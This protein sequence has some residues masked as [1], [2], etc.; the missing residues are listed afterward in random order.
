ML[1]PRNGECISGLGEDEVSGFPTSPPF[2]SHLPDLSQHNS[3]ATEVLRESPEIYANLKNAETQFG[4]T[5]GH[6]IKSG[7]DLKGHPMI[8]KIGLHAGDE[9]SYEVFSQLFKPVLAR[10]HIQ[11]PQKMSM[12]LRRLPNTSRLKQV[13]FFSSRNLSRYRFPSVMERIE[14][15]EVEAILK[16]VLDKCFRGRYYPG[17][18]IPQ[19]V[20]EEMAQSDFELKP[21]DSLVL[22]SAGFGRD[23]PSGRGLYRISSNAVAHLNGENH[24]KVMVCSQGTEQEMALRTGFAEIN[25]LMDKIESSLA[26]FHTS[27]AR[28]GDGYLLSCISSSGL[29]LRIVALVETR[30]RVRE[31]QRLRE[32]KN[33]RWFSQLRAREFGEKGAVESIKQWGDGEREITLVEVVSD[34]SIRFEHRNHLF[35]HFAGVMQ[36][37]LEETHFEKEV[38]EYRCKVDDRGSAFQLDEES[39][40]YHLSPRRETGEHRSAS[41]VFITGVQVEPPD[42]VTSPCQ[43][44]ITLLDSLE[45]AS[46]SSTN[47]LFKGGPIALASTSS[48]TGCL[49][50]K[51]SPT[52]ALASTTSTT[53]SNQVSKEPE[54]N[55]CNEPKCFVASTSSNAD[56]GCKEPEAVPFSRLKTDKRD[57]I[58]EIRVKDEIDSDS[59]LLDLEIG[60]LRAL[61]TLLINRINDAS[62]TSHCLDKEYKEAQSRAHSCHADLMKQ[63]EKMEEMKIQAS[64]LEKEN[65]ELCAAL[66]LHRLEIRHKH[67]EAELAAHRIGYPEK[68]VRDRSLG[69]SPIASALR[70]G[71]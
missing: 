34:S 28:T 41:P 24:L 37:V 2:P 9:Q 45:T 57:E 38:E 10:L 22:L 69:R 46:T 70:K 4:V 21:P 50:S 55:E 27:F 32:Q 61:N 18:S 62:S 39:T 3:I 6:I 36:E 54:D 60:E 64:E 33:N 53:H 23:W 49:I 52:K 48:P 7:I 15:L 29:A 42:M 31:L 8:Q 17:R 65:R 58:P 19:K 56:K 20:H 47:H 44:T 63:Q 30:I 59:E 35:N 26:S 40:G 67:L 1:S 5:I 68:R 13:K 43:T 71:S 12:E 51:E 11:S 14:R 16:N 25:R 66:D